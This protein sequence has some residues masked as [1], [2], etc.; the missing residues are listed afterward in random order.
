MPR[1]V[2]VVIGPLLLRKLGVWGRFCGLSPKGSR[3][4]DARKG[5]STGVAKGPGLT[6]VP[7]LVPHVQRARDLARAI[8]EIQRH[9]THAVRQ[10]VHD[11]QLGAAALLAHD[12]D[13]DGTHAHLDRAAVLEPAHTRRLQQLELVPHRVGDCD[14]TALC[15][16]GDGA[17]RPDLEQR[18][19]RRGLGVALG[20]GVA[21]TRVQLQRLANAAQLGDLALDSAV[22]GAEREARCDQPAHDT[23]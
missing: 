12:G 18:V 22:T 17:H 1:N 2:C 15:Q 23:G 7:R 4:M 9:H 13:R 21:V 10:M 5:S 6:M 20:R 14:E 19:V 16:H 3:A 11:P 8:G